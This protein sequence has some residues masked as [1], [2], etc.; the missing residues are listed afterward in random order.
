MP[1]PFSATDLQNARLNLK[2]AFRD[3]PLVDKFITIRNTTFSR[4]LRNELGSLDASEMET[5]NS[6]C[7]RSSPF[8]QVAPKTKDTALGFTTAEMVFRTRFKARVT[9]APPIRVIR[10]VR[11]AQ[12]NFL[13]NSVKD[14]HTIP[15]YVTYEK[16]IEKNVRPSPKYVRDALVREFNRASWSYDGPREEFIRG[17]FENEDTPGI[18][19]SALPYGIAA[20]FLIVLYDEQARKILEVGRKMATMAV[21]KDKTV[22]FVMGP[23]AMLVLPETP[24]SATTTK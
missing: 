1:L 12:I 3:Q 19:E 6:L 14:E 4:C 21:W 7:R 2:G 22:Q 16:G 23:P 15:G 18:K 10:F 17:T 8:V 24:A 20:D 11:A 5:L 9:P 13:F